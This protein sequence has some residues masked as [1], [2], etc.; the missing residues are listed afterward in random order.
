MLGAFPC[1]WTKLGASLHRVCVGLCQTQY[2]KKCSKVFLSIL[3]KYFVDPFLATWIC[4]PFL[5]TGKFLLMFF[6]NLSHFLDLFALF[7]HFPDLF[8]QV[9]PVTCSKIPWPW[10]T[11]FGAC[12]ITPDALQNSRCNH[13][14]MPDI[15]SIMCIFSSVDNKPKNQQSLRS[16]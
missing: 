7:C 8:G 12:H 10:C 2:T 15:F 5:A 16:C 13:T 4:L 11:E 14:T 1:L 6:G 9:S 3:E